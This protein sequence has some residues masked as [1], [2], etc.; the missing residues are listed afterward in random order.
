MRFLPLTL[1]VVALALV[2]RT[3]LTQPAA[4]STETGEGAEGGEGTADGGAGEADA[5][6]E[7]E[8]APPPEPELTPYQVHMNN[9]VRLFKAGL[10]DGAIAE[11]QAAYDA[12]PKASPLINLALTHKKLANPVKAIDVLETALAKHRDTMPA[13][14]IA[15][16]EREI[17]EM[18]A[19]LAY[20]KV[21][22]RPSLEQVELFV[23]DVLRP[24]FRPGDEL[25]LPPGMRRFR[26]RAEGFAETDE[27]VQITSGRNNPPVTLDLV[28]THGEV[29]ITARH[30]DAWIEVDSVKKAK[31][32]HRQMLSPGVHVVRVIR[33]DQIDS[34]QIVVTAGER[35]AVTQDEDG[36]LESDA[37]A[38]LEQPKDSPFGVE[39]PQYLR[40]F[41]ALGGV[42][43]LTP[44][45]TVRHIETSDPDFGAGI[46]VR[47]GYRVTDWAGFEG[48][49]QY[50][51]LRIAGTLQV[52]DRTSEFQGREMTMVLESLRL[53]A[54][55]RVMVPGDG[56]VRFAGTI[57]GGA[58]IEKLEWR[59][60]PEG[61]RRGTEGPAIYVDESGVG[62]FGQLDLGVELEFQNILIDVMAQLI[63]QGTKHFDLDNDQNV[64]ET[65]PILIMGPAIRGGYSLW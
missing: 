46:D 1:L 54:L 56:W 2:P 50:S 16:A 60:E 37:T 53:G 15:A 21:N 43:L 58:V 30:T 34:I 23:D 47:L 51:D 19:L 5:T 35:Y 39:V 57:G 32:L 7:P 61:G 4:P 29:I 40:G 63:V 65:R 17:R 28:P 36:E 45:A 48:V 27:R 55:L 41:Y 62:P 9:G 38:P 64:F 52:A 33:G 8:E 11:F 18:K 3:A 24:E 59:D 25:V 20:V 44:L 49:A 22:V 26:V 42:A 10:W 14:Q 12:E 31:G 6:A 13:D